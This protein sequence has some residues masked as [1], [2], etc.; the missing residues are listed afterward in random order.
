MEY[1]ECDLG[2]FLGDVDLDLSEEQAKTLTYNLLLAIKFLHSTRIV[3]RDIKPQNI[4]ITE[5]CTV[6][7]CDFGFARSVR[8]E[9]SEKKKARPMSPVCYALWYRPPEV[10]FQK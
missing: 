3:H 7:L 9:E 8:I 2:K 4:L 6:K 10:Y 5:D 1:I